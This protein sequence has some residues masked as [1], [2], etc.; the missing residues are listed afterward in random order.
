MEICVTQDAM[1][2]L[3]Y[4]LVLCYGIDHCGTCHAIFLDDVI[5]VY[6]GICFCLRTTEKYPGP[7]NETFLRV[8]V[9]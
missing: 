1:A 4:I 9:R 2:D 7:I 5:A 8:G 6:L 3:R